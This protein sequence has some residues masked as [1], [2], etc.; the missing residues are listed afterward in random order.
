MSGEK[1]R[2]AVPGREADGRRHAEAEEEE[3]D[4]KEKIRFFLICFLFDPG[5]DHSGS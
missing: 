1:E 2:A 3:E 5:Y 4:L